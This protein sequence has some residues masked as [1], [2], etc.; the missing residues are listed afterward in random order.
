MSK[1]LTVS[2][3]DEDIRKGEP[4]DCFKCPIAHATNRALWA[5]QALGSHG[6]SASSVSN[7]LLSLTSSGEIFW[8]G[9][10]PHEAR[11]FIVSFD[12]D[13]ECLPFDFEI[14]L[15]RTDAS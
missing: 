1:T 6:G 10:L 15:E 13:G 11:D 8:I 5:H 7:S 12:A 3:S 14:E 4:A 9:E 2:V